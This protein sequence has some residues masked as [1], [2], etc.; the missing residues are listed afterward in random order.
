MVNT[1]WFNAD[2]GRDLHPLVDHMSKL[3]N[4]SQQKIELIKHL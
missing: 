1:V 2:H 4:F 3:P